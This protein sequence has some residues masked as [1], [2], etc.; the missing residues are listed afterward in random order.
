MKAARCGCTSALRRVRFGLRSRE[1]CERAEELHFIGLKSPE[2]GTFMALGSLHRFLLVGCQWCVC[3]ALHA[4]LVL[5]G[6]LVSIVLDP[7]EWGHLQMQLSIRI[8][9]LVSS[10]LCT[11]LLVSLSVFV[12]RSFSFLLIL[13][14][15][16][17]FVHSFFTHL[18]SFENS[19]YY[20]DLI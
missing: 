17:S 2:C 6:R 1:T 18:I 7:E 15:S 10:L 5:G 3:Q 19:R 8:F 4:R 14:S 20:F 9:F 11:G 13:T 16:C 12:P